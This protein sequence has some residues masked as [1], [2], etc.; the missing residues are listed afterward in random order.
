VIHVFDKNTGKIKNSQLI[1]SESSQFYFNDSS[2]KWPQ[3]LLKTP[4]LCS[5]R[6]ILS[7]F[8]YELSKYYIMTL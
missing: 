1:R 4:K 6:L 7:G 5:S 3:F 8:L 2:E